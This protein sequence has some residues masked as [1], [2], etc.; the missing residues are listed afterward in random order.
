MRLKEMQ[1]CSRIWKSIQF[2][3]IFSANA[4]L[5]KLKFLYLI[6][7]KS[8]ILSVKNRKLPLDWVTLINNDGS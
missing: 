3:R 5:K 6:Q 4:F 2:S 7:N 8:I 1:E